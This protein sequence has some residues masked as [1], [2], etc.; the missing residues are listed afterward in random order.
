MF[1]EYRLSYSVNLEVTALLIFTLCTTLIDSLL[2][3]VSESHFYN[4]MHRKS[5]VAASP[6]LFLISLLKQDR[7]SDCS[8]QVQDLQ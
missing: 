6:S 4:F 5:S 1:L 2:M 3:I 8:L 7:H